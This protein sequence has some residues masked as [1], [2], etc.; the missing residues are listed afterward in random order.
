MKILLLVI[1]REVLVKI[2][3]VSIMWQLKTPCLLNI[4]SYLINDGQVA[5]V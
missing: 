5:N 4:D 3:I 1:M 2:I